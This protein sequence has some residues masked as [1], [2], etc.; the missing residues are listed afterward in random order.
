MKRNLFVLSVAIASQLTLHA[1]TQQEPWLN[2]NTTRV[3][4]EA[5]RSSFFAYESADKA[6]KA[7]KHSSSRYLSL[8]GKWR[9]NFVK[10][11]AGCGK[12]M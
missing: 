9:F 2:P 6:L 7:D 3:N 8:E 10:K 5:P 11:N 12:T 4:T 1:Q